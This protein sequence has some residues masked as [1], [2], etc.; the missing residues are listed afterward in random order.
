HGPRLAKRISR[1]RQQTPHEHGL[2]R[3]AFAWLRWDRRAAG[4]QADLARLGPA[5]SAV[6]NAFRDGALSPR[7]AALVAQAV[8]PARQPQA[9]AFARSVTLRRLEDVLGT[10][11]A[12]QGAVSFAAPPEAASVF[13]VALEAVRSHLCEDQRPGA[14]S[15]R[16]AVC[17]AREMSL[18]MGLLESARVRSGVGGSVY[19]QT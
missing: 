12:E 5:G 9:V 2:R 14:S 17:I 19:T 15:A 1:A 13:L 8:P 4:T 10:G 16:R 6:A 11:G 18:G 3:E 7:Q